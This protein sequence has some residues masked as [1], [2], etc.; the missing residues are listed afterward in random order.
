[1]KAITDSYNKT[2]NILYYI[3][4]YG[5]VNKGITK[6]DSWSVIVSILLRKKDHRTKIWKQCKIIFTYYK[7]VALMTTTQVVVFRYSV[8]FR[9][10]VV[11]DSATPW[12]A[13]HQASL[14]I[15]N[16]PSLLKLKST[17]LV[18]PSN[19]LILSSPSPLP[20]DLSQHESF[21]IP[22]YWRNAFSDF[23]MYKLF[24]VILSLPTFL[25]SNW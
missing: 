8:Q 16:S 19:H 22:R 4:M 6:Y 1:M 17:Q 15:V 9:C 21:P 23:L 10:S 12:T 25:P 5:R 13:A 24:P 18:T 2:C 20:F 7:R 11:S 14:S 3:V